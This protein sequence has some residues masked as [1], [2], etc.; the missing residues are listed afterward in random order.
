MSPMTSVAPCLTLIYPPVHDFSMPYLSLPLLKRYVEDNTRVKCEIVDFNQQFFRDIIDYSRKR[1]IST[2]V[3]IKDFALTVSE[4]IELQSIIEKKI[5]HFSNKYPN[6]ALSLRKIKTPFDPTKSDIIFAELQSEQNM[7]YPIFSKFLKDPKYKRSGIFGISVGVEDQVFPSFVLASIIK[8]MFPQSKTVLG[9]NIITR[10]H[11]NIIKSKLSKYI[12][13]MVIR[14]GEDAFVELVKYHLLNE[15][16]KISHPK[17]ISINNNTIVSNEDILKNIFDIK[18]IKTP[19]FRGFNL[20]SYLSPIPILPIFVTRKCYWAK[21][22]FCSIHTSWDHISRTRDISQVMADIELYAKQ[23]VNHFRIV[24]EDCPPMILKKLSEEILNRNHNIFFEAYSRFEREFLDL[25]FCKKLAEAGCRQLFWG[26]ESIGEETLKL[27]TKIV[28]CKDYSEFVDKILENT[29]SAGILNY[30]FVLIGIP[31]APVR[32]EAETINYIIKNK[33]TH[34]V[35]PASFVVDKD[36]PIHLNDDI[37]SKYGIQLLDVGDMTTEIGYTING[38][39][40]RNR[41][42]KRTRRYAEK[43][44]NMRPDLALS[45]LFNDEIRFILACEFGNNF[46][47]EFISMCNKDKINNI[48]DKAIMKC[49]EERIN[50]KL[51]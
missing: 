11:D 7:F 3:G 18:K 32:N 47:N 33:N 44:Y 8:K 46:A 17:I 10:L 35:I 21:C 13:Y 29:N 25:D 22:D 14:E 27:T 49:Y 48:I 23:G 41:T 6:Y 20:E 51:E 42:Q 38:R 28:N 1:E 9:G 37:R 43:I 5:K 24:D 30:I 50:R 40:V 2:Y 45:T 4:S 34:V 31:N 19:D 16:K 15:I 26:L 12:D 39:D 36:S